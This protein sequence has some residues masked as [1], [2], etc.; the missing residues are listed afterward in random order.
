MGVEFDA[1]ELAAVG[2]AGLGLEKFGLLG[3][4]GDRSPAIVAWGD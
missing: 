1:C 2:V 4:G 3:V